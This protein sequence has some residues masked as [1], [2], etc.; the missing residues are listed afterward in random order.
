MSIINKAFSKK[1]NKN[2][3]KNVLVQQI[4]NETMTAEEI[5][6]KK[7]QASNMHAY[8]QTILMTSLQC[9][10]DSADKL[11]S[12]AGYSA[13]ANIVNVKNTV[14]RLK[15]GLL[16]NIKG[17]TVEEYSDF[18]K[19]NVSFIQKVIN[20]SLA[21]SAAQ[22]TTF[23]VFMA[24]IASWQNAILSGKPSLFFWVKYSDEEQSLAYEIMGESIEVVHAQTPGFYSRVLVYT[25]EG[26]YLAYYETETKTFLKD[27]GERILAT[28]DDLFMDVDMMC[29]TL[30]NN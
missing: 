18:L 24:K 9:A 16:K 2:L 26:C 15:D 25:P 28:E 7:V 19:D 23:L 6:L 11:F 21:V 29:S 3:G 5:E 10:I 22:R 20:F 14:K 8:T 4:V 1:L 30:K 27:N 13:R 17:G 12:S